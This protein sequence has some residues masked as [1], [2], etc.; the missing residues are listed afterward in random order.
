MSKNTKVVLR[1]VEKAF[2]DRRRGTKT[3]ALHDISVDIEDSEFLCLLGPSGCGKSTVL[4]LIAGF[5]EPTQ[6]D[7]LI[8]GKP[9]EK[10]GPDRGMIFQTAEL[11]PWLT[12]MEN[13][14]FGPRL[15]HADKEVYIPA[16]ERYMRL[17]GLTGFERHYPYEL[18]GGMRQR[19]AL[20]RVW[21]TEPSLFLMDEPFG[22]L[23]A[24]TRLL[25][26]ELLLRLWREAQRT[27]L[28]VT[29]DVDEGIF[30]GDRILLMSAHP[31]E[32]RESINIPFKRPRVY[33]DLIF[34]AEYN[35]IKQ[36]V[37]Q[38]LREESQ[39]LI[40]THAIE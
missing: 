1:N 18:S 28:F 23:D 11:F 30:L 36:H 40:D 38:A 12:V 6:G 39:H 31:G 3:V 25:M 32:I 4:N 33:D 19:V 29:H 35:E 15:A 21:I 16:A 10:P 37:M 26:Q 13:I 22:A 2:E 17:M 27:S 8:D 5:E 34:G 24:Q 9:V 7:V 14:T 20:A